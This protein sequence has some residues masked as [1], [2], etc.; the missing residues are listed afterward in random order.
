MN[1]SG[2]PID[3]WNVWAKQVKEMTGG[4]IEISVFGA[5]TIAPRAE[6]LASVAAGVLDI[7]RIS[8]GDLVNKL[9]EAPL[10]HEIPGTFRDIDDLMSLIDNYGWMDLIREIYAE[11]GAFYLGPSPGAGKPWW[12]KKPITKA[13]EIKG[14]K[15]RTFGLMS[16]LFQALGASTTMI[17]HTES[18]M[19]LKLGT[20]DAY[21]TSMV[22]YVDNKHYEITPY[23]MMPALSGVSGPAIVANMRVWQSLSDDLK[24]ILL[25]AARAQAYE[26]FYKAE[27]QPGTY[28]FYKFLESV[29]KTGY[30]ITFVQMGDEL[31]NA[32]AVAGTK[33]LDDAGSKS[34]RA[35]RMAND[36]KALMKFKGYI[37]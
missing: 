27:G 33:I 10:M 25:V 28:L 16:N 4:R 9:P 36:M 34:P 22:V 7:S 21:S 32:I 8:P 30:K 3:I 5:D 15:V 19:A 37:K 23:V 26:V 13:E 35:Q 31:L 2:T 18:Y 17:P 12:A 1:A 24:E 14:M 20:V 29:Q 6:V 11:Q